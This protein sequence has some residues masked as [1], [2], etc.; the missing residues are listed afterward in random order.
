MLR[1][2]QVSL[3]SIQS[4]P[5]KITIPQEIERYFQGEN[6]EILLEWLDDLEDDEIK[7]FLGNLS[8][9]IKDAE[10][11]KLD[12]VPVI[13]QYKDTK[14][15]KLK[16]TYFERWVEKESKIFFVAL[17]GFSILFFIFFGAI[18]LVGA[19]EKKL[20]NAELFL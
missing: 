16:K 4:Y 13:N 1:E 12:L 9:V 19:I 3:E 17:S 11:K 18:L 20:R 8:V 2:T 14:L 15:Q 6:R 7:D 10:K 5:K